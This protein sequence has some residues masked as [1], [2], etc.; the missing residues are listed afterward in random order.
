MA[1]CLRSSV[2]LQLALD[3]MVVHV[4][5]GW[6]HGLSREQI[7]AHEEAM[8][9]AVAATG[10]TAP[11]QCIPLQLALASL[12]AA[13]FAAQAPGETQAGGPASASGTAGTHHLSLNAVVSPG[14]D[15]EAV[16]SSC[17]G[18]EAV[19]SPGT[20]AGTASEESLARLQQLLADLPDVTGR[21]DLLVHL[22][23]AL[24]QRV[25]A[26]AGC[27]KIARGTC[28][29]ALAVLV[30]SET[31]KV[32]GALHVLARAHV[33]QRVKNLFIVFWGMLDSVGPMSLSCCRVEGF[34]FQ[35]SC[36]WQ[37][38]GMAPAL[39]PPSSRAA[40]S[41]PRSLCGSAGE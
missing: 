26:Q 14:T 15:Q 39:P 38:R 9:A 37:M 36:P 35:R 12:P 7:E 33:T 31:A 1:N 28:A 19:A 13:P 20:G 27:H 25:A 41:R 32:R 30:I 6:V 21:E 5:E 23:W 22:R 40:R 18:Q 3:L 10:C 8:R 2:P 16:V 24:L 29:D 34:R 4:Q 11:L 17:T